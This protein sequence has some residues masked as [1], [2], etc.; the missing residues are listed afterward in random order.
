MTSS[1]IA[2]FSKNYLQK[3]RVCGQNAPNQRQGAKRQDE[4]AAV[5]EYR[6]A[7]TALPATS[8]FNLAAAAGRL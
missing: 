6:P 8:G 3:A 1:I 2:E 4:S 7:L 5:A